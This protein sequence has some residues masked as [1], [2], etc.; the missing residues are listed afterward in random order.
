MI[1]CY[2]L[3]IACRFIA[4]Q[5]YKAEW[6][7]GAISRANSGLGEFACGVT[8]DN[9]AH[10]LLV[11][12]STVPPRGDSGGSLLAVTCGPV[13]CLFHSNLGVKAVMNPPCRQL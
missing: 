9:F 1:D 12:I 4:W 8:V 3:R 2:S 13:I 7:R 6:I 10:K 5:H 11:K